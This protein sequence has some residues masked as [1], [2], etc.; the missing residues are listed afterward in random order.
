MILR[1]W[2]LWPAQPKYFATP[3]FLNIEVKVKI[4]KLATERPCATTEG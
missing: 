3:Q 4:F 2:L 1:L